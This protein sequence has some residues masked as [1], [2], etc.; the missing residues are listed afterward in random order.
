MKNKMLFRL[1]VD[2]NNQAFED[3]EE[4][5]RILESAISKLK[6]G[7]ETAKLKDINGNTVGTYTIF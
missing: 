5:I 3:K 2:M 6:D 1:S 7:N 4:L